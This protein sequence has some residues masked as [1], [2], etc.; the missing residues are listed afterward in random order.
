M[1]QRVGV[2]QKLKSAGRLGLKVAIGAGAVAGLALGIK[3]KGE[4]KFEEKKQEVDETIGAA[5]V[6]AG[7]V[8]GI[9]Q[10]TAKDVAAKPFQAK[11]AVAKGKMMA[12]GV[13]AT[14]AVDPVG[15][16]KQVKYAT[17]PK[18]DAPVVG[19]YPAPDPRVT[20]VAAFTPEMSSAACQALCYQQNNPSKHPKRYRKCIAKC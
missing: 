11:K 18:T 9:G 17:A 14:A 4:E 15:A 12:T 20:R 7:A 5:K 10:A 1:S 16:A 2:K 19:Q 8:K 3:G 13:V 6:V